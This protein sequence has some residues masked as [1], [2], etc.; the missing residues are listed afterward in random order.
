[1]AETVQPAPAEKAAIK[2][3]AAKPT[4]KAAAKPTG[5]KTAAPKAVAKAQPAQG[6]TENVKSKVKSDMNDFKAKATDT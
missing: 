5:A 2:P 1:M 4:A 3:A 6:K